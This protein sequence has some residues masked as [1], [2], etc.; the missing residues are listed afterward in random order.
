MD[1]HT[2]IPYHTIPY[3]TIPLHYITLH[4][5]DIEKERLSENGRLCHAD[6]WNHTQP[7]NPPHLCRKKQETT[8]ILECQCY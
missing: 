6:L 3:H 4:T 5:Y 2:Y 8:E 7:E 1:K